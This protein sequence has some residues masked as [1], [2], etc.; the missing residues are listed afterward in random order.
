M[1]FLFHLAIWFGFDQINFSSDIFSLTC[2]ICC[3]LI[4]CIMVRLHGWT[5][6][7]VIGCEIVSDLPV[8]SGPIVQWSRKISVSSKWT[9]MQTLE[10][11]NFVKCGYRNPFQLMYN[12]YKWCSLNLANACC[13][14]LL[15]DREIWPQSWLPGNAAAILG[16]PNIEI[17]ASDGQRW[18]CSSRMDLLSPRWHHFIFVAT[19]AVSWLCILSLEPGWWWT[20][21]NGNIFRVT[22]PWWRESTSD[23]WIPLT[24]ASDAELWCALWS[25]HEQ[26]VKQPT[27][28]QVILGRHHP[29]YDVTVRWWIWEVSRDGTC[30]SRGTKVY[31]QDTGL[32]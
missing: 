12:I 28:P 13:S 18:K 14:N 2:L 15:I 5:L 22:G 11:I 4:I 20:S 26:T 17:P 29:H 16:C 7:T 23:R 8:Q 3:W 9:D 32:G 24:R 25:A 31:T 30:I 27:E 1:T 19:K 10:S 21:S 6:Y